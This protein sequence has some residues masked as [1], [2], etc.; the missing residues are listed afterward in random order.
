M[1]STL[2]ERIRAARM[3]AGLTLKEI[4]E[5]CGVT[6]VAA[7]LWENP[8][9]AKRTEPSIGK[10]RK[11]ADATGAPLDWLVSD[12]SVI[13]GDWRKTIAAEPADT[14]RVHVIGSGFA[15]LAAA[16]AAD[17]KLTVDAALAAG[18]GKAVD[19]IVLHNSL[20]KRAGAEGFTGY[21][22]FAV[23]A[24]DDALAPTVQA[25]DI[26]VMSPDGEI[27][28]KRIIGLAVHDR[29]TFRQ[30]R[31]AYS[32][33]GTLT[34]NLAATSGE[35]RPYILAGCGPANL[36][37]GDLDKCTRAGL[38]DPASVP[39]A[40]FEIPAPFVGLAL[41]LRRILM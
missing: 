22:V 34:A 9:D 31:A 24:S 10:L 13:G 35:Y 16:L 1:S 4:G 40:N 33:D 20:A 5:V 15:E 26:I 37:G 28:N 32:D 27:R 36:C 41:G 23:I 29:V 6:R 19:E 8:D 25:D 39:S 2:R 14:V 18:A 21:R 7:G 30:C 38:S 3:A 11:I 12:D 17:R